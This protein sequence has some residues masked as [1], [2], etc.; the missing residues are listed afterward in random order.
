M[1]A[2]GDEY[3]PDVGKWFVSDP[4]VFSRVSK[5]GLLIVV[6]VLFGKGLSDFG[7]NELNWDIH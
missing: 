1:Y 6:R 7:K 3:L 4:G 5:N 2:T